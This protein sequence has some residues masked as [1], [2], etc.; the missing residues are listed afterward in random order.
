MVPTRLPSI[1]SEIA[2]IS[3]KLIGMS[4]NKKSLTCFGNVQMI[5]PNTIRGKNYFFMDWLMSLLDLPLVGKRIFRILIIHMNLLTI[6]LINSM[7]T[8]L[9]Y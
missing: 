4:F 5:Q 1:M 8:L 2:Q 6:V 7:R 3:L 9:V